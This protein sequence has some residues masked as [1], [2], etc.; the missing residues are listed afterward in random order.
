MD[1]ADP[2]LPLWAWLVP[3]M[4]CSHVGPLAGGQVMELAHKIPW[5]THTWALFH[6]PLPAGV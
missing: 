3:V 5:K 4:K 6:I 2:D 1:L